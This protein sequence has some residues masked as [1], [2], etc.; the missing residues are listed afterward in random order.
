MLIS[1]KITGVLLVCTIVFSLAFSEALSV[2]QLIPE[3]RKCEWK[4]EV[5]RMPEELTVQ[6]PE[7]A[8]ELRSE[9]E[10][11]RRIRFS[12]SKLYFGETNAS[13]RL[14]LEEGF[15]KEGY[16][17]CISSQGG[18][19]IAAGDL[20]GLFYG[21][22]TLDNLAMISGPVLPGCVI[23]DYPSLPIRGIF[24]NISRLQSSGIPNLKKL[25]DL[26]SS[27]KM[28]TLILEFG[29]NLPFTR[30]KFSQKSVLTKEELDEI[31]QYAKSKHIEIVP[32]LQT[33]S[34]VRWLAAHSDFSALLENPQEASR[35]DCNW[36]PSNPQVRQIA[37]DVITETIE[38][39]RPRYFH[40]G[41]DEI[42][43]GSFGTCKLCKL[44]KPEQLFYNH[45]AELLGTVR[46]HGAI[47]IVYHDAFMPAELS[48]AAGK[49]HGNKA[50]SVLSPDT[51]INVWDYESDPSF[52]Q[53][54]PFV[55]LGLPVWGATWL[56]QMG[57]N[58]G[59]PRLVAAQ[60]KLGEGNILTFWHYMPNH[61]GAWEEIGNL[62]YPGIVYAANYSWNTD[63][64]ALDELWLDPTF[65]A[66]RRLVPDTVPVLQGKKYQ[67]ISLRPVVNTKFGK[68]RL[69]PVFSESAL[70]QLKRE[71]AALPE[72]FELL[73]GDDKAYYGILLSGNPGSSLPS[74]M[75]IE[76]DRKADALT[77]LL[78]TPTPELASIYE[79]PGQV[80]NMPMCGR[81]IAEYADGMR[82]VLPL[83]YRWNLINWNFPFG[84]LM[85]RFVN[86]TKTEDGALAQFPAI[87][88]K[89][90]HPEKV[91]RRIILESV[92]KEGVAPMLLAL[93]ALV[94]NDSSDTPA[95][96]DSA[97]LSSVKEPPELHREV[98]RETLADF[99]GKELRISNDGGFEGKLLPRINA[100]GI[101]FSV[102]PLKAALPRSRVIIDLPIN[103][104]KGIKALSFSVTS[105]NPQAIRG[106][107]VY[108][109]TDGYRQ[110]LVKYSAIT[111]N[112]A[113]EASPVVLLLDSMTHEGD[114]L[115]RSDEVTT[116]RIALWLDNRTPLNIRISP[117]Y[118]YDGKPESA[119]KKWYRLIDKVR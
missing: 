9:L 75:N 4:S 39:V 79:Q 104:M 14:L 77:F 98:R 94:P 24:M 68:S 12:G 2:S 35:W 10:E 15:R 112:R 107:A 30:Q 88:W 103:C 95:V 52:Q 53:M 26:Y 63:S 62:V 33:L 78:T 32:C 43:H 36:C 116:M 84:G 93:S 16:R 44:Q 96:F 34:H 25:I 115:P 18:I 97:D 76:L 60:D 11:L 109:G 48:Y 87:D 66:R 105:S 65:E 90:P 20:N 106:S 89:N 21:L 91:I 6:L 118:Q 59:M 28:N 92:Q 8:T 40:I 23:E 49:A 57:N 47:P 67:P 1:R 37:D 113:G 51:R 42:G 27:L 50:I 119:E 38:M 55:K 101:E 83:R 81:I 73:T 41:L 71:L 108:L 54:E 85:S 58:R 117:V 70:L 69:A 31:L 100:D 111:L 19:E 72:A 45:V 82:E 102:P 22:K 74:Q 86:R 29:T 114:R 80:R 46:K 13:I 56:P 61:I 99:R 110:T 5:F 64:A 3:V 17:L 7:R